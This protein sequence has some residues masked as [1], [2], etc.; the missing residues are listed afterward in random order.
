MVNLFENLFEKE[1]HNM[2]FVPCAPKYREGR[3]FSLDSEIGTG[4][5]WEYDQNG[6]FLISEMDL[7]LNANLSLSFSHNTEMKV[8]G[9]FDSES[10]INITG[11]SKVKPTNIKAELSKNDSYGIDYVGNRRI[12]GMSIVL[13]PDYLDELN[14]KYKSENKLSVAFSSY[15]SVPKN[16]FSDIQN[17]RGTGISSKLFYEGKVLEMLSHLYRYEMEKPTGVTE[18][19]LIIIREIL[20]FI[21]NNICIPLRVSQL[22]EMAHMSS[23]KF[24]SV[25]KSVAKC[26]ASD[27]ILKSRMNVANSLLKQKSMSIAEVAYRVGYKKASA[28]SDTYRAYFQELPSETKSR[29]RIL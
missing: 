7:T 26:T 28:F 5:F 12:K 15:A 17:Y 11:Q 16:I 14:E 9:R 23:T 4:S 29:L 24:K 22:A 25:F 10:G 19:D 1:L 27:Y 21:D 3:Q 6:L 20:A 13:L 8:I 18:D 2:G